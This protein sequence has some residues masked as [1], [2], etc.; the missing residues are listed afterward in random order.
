MGSKQASERPGRQGIKRKRGGRGKV[1]RRGRGGERV[2][3][4][5]EEGKVDREKKKAN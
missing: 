1:K 2:I 3:K 4:G 5:R